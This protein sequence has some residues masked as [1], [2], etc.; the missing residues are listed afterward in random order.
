MYTGEAAC[1]AVHN[2]IK[3]KDNRY[4]H[5]D[6]V[7]EDKKGMKYLLLQKQRRCYWKDIKKNQVVHV[8]TQKIM[9]VEKRST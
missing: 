5:R 6:E 2:L 8:Y 3:N 7:K 1:Q 4:I 9:C